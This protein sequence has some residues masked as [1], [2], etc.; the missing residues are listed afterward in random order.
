MKEETR[1]AVFLGLAIAVLLAITVV[2][3]GVLVTKKGT[4]TMDVEV[5]FVVTDATSGDPIGNAIIKLRE[6]DRLD[7]A[8]PA[9]EIVLR[10]DRSGIARQVIRECRIYFSRGAFENETVVALP[11][12]DCQIR[13]DGYSGVS[14]NVYQLQRRPVAE[15]EGELAMVSIPIRLMRELEEVR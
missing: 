12:W 6:G 10:T 4:G 2:A 8:T 13:A 14:R 15:C 5:S 7:N 9:E 11:R 1:K 3:T